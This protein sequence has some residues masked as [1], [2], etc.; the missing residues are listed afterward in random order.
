[1]NHHGKFKSY[2]P[3]VSQSHPAF[4]DV[5]QR[6]LAVTHPLRCSTWSPSACSSDWV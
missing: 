5:N 6:V 4:L 3:T 2:A 1:L